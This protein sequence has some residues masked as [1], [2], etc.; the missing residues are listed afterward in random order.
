MAK[1]K[2]RRTKATPPAIPR[3]LRTASPTQARKLLSSINHCWDALD[4]Q[5]FTLEQNLKKL[6]SQVPRELRTKY[7]DTLKSLTQACNLIHGIECSGPF[8]SFELPLLK[9]EIKA[10]VRTRRPRR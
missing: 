2:P 3:G 5:R 4:Y 1:A 8:M 7:R 6:G 9:G 10:D